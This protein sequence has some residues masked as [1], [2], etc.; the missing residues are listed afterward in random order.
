MQDYVGRGFRDH[1]SIFPV[2]NYHLFRS[3]VTK[4]TFDKH[5]QALQ[6]L[7][8]RCNQIDSL[9]GKIAKLEKRGGGDK[10]AP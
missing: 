2:I 6:K 4:S 9:Q 3:S 7:E 5:K 1:Q 10:G 8:L